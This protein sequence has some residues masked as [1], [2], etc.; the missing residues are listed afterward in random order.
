VEQAPIP[1]L[2][3]YLTLPSLLPHLLGD[4]WPSLLP[5]VATASRAL[6]RL[7][8][9]PRWSAAVKA[10]GWEGQSDVAA[11]DS[12]GS[13]APCAILREHRDRENPAP[14]LCGRGYSE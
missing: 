11:P 5:S 9:V 1:W 14:S 7:A 10:T 4:L 12:T 3:L 2:A 6:V 13:G 8:S